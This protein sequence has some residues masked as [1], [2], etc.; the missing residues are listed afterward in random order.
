[1][2]IAFMFSGQGSQYFGMG[3]E[4]YESNES[5]KEVFDCASQVCG[6]SMP[7]LCFTENDRLNQTE[8]TQPAILTMSIALTRLIGKSLP[9]P[10]YVFGL[11]LGEYS[12]LVKSDALDF[13][14]ALKLIKKRGEL[15]ANALPAGVGA[16]TAV[17]NADEAL[18]ADICQRAAQGQVC[19]ISNYNAPGQIVISG[20]REAIERAEELFKQEGVRKTMRLKVSGAF[21]SPLLSDAAEQLEAEL[22]NIE[23]KKMSTYVV[24]NLTAGTI[25]SK[26]DIVPTL[27]AQLVSPVRFKESV[28]FL[29]EK[30][31]DNFVEIGPGKTL[32][33][34]VKKISNNVNTYNIEDLKS[35]EST[36][37]SLWIERK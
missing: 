31:V 16:M 36:V 30:K 10:D 4:L 2:K 20:N 21:H 37:T 11:S 25:K 3:K 33:S 34:F 5:V 1:M 14:S 18:I 19:V 13:V 12:A 15:M 7:D 24:S 23:F 8:Y 22:R 27:K 9:S 6:Y 29:I 28:E 26:D 35:Y 32:C 17:M